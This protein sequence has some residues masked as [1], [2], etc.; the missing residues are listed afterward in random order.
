M[1]KQ[2]LIKKITEKKE[3]SNLPEIDVKLAF[4]K[5]ENDKYLDEEKIKFTRDLLRKVFS[6]FMSQKILSIKELIYSLQYI[7]NR[8]KYE[9]NH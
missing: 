1:N 5:F 9:L 6:A 7:Y 8:L 4:E 3:F 2:E